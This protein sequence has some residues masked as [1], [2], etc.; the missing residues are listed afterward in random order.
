ME[1]YALF[2]KPGELDYTEMVQTSGEPMRFDSVEALNGHSGFVI[3]PF[4]V[5]CDCPVLLLQPDKIVKRAFPPMQG[6]DFAP[7]GNVE[8]RISL[9]DDYARDFSSFHSRIAEGKFSKIVLARQSVDVIGNPEPPR[10]LFER[11]CHLY[12]NMFVALVSTPL[13]GTWLTATPEL[14]LE[15][16]GDEYH[17]IALAGTMGLWGRTLWNEKNKNEQQYVASYIEEC[18]SEFSHECSCHG[19]YTVSAGDVCH[20]RTDFSFSLKDKAQLGDFLAK[21]HPTPAVCGLPKSATIDFILENESVA[22][23]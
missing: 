18:I 10:R 16:E 21:L 3:A 22:R 13:S 17:T 20:L 2:R 1:S 15:S 5:T 4:A 6:Y 19:P 23:R 14:L 9:R 11:A 8:K 12:S 7:E